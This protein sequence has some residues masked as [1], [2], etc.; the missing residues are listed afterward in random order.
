LSFFDSDLGKRLCKAQ[1]VWREVPFSLSLAAKEVY[2][3][4]IN[5]EEPVLM[6]GV[7]DCLFLEE[8]QIVIIDYKSD[9]VKDEEEMALKAKSYI[10]QLKSYA[11]AG[12]EILQKKVTAAYL[13]FLRPAKEFLCF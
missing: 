1:K 7:V 11:R 9:E 2:P 5:S 6:Q 13:Y 10:P 12:E 4:L 3:E 8:D